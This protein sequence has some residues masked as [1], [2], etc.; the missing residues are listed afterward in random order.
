MSEFVINIP[1]GLTFAEMVKMGKY[2]W[3]NEWMVKGFEADQTLVGRWKCDLVLP[4][5]VISTKRGV[6]LCS[7]DGWTAPKIDHLLLFGLTF[8]Q[9]QIK[10]CIVGLGSTCIGEFKNLTAPFL[11]AGVRGRGLGLICLSSKLQTTYRI[12]RVRKENE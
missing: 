4:K 6:K 2:T 9:E 10:G 5:R 7:D 1:L 8:P 11:S 3:V 12:L